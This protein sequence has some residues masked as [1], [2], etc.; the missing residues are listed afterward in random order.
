MHA[1]YVW[2]NEVNNDQLQTEH[3]QVFAVSPLSQFVSR[4][5]VRRDDELT[6]LSFGCQQ[7]GVQY[8]E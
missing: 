6:G 7:P 2:S 5:Q 8:D 3:G 4:A 1:L